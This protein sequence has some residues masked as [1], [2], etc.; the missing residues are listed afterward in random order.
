MN[1]TRA[2]VANVQD[3][4]KRGFNRYELHSSGDVLPGWRG[5]SPLAVLCRKTF[6]LKRPREV[7]WVVA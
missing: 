1:A 5:S 3:A 6:D 2:Q 4:R 7:W